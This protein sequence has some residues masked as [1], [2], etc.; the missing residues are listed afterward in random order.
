[1]LNQSMRQD[2]R[3]WLELFETFNDLSVFQHR[4][5]SSNADI[6]LFTDSAAGFALGFG[7]YF[8]DRW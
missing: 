5:W 2:L 8:R 4:Y 3:I 1:M 7:A 6:N